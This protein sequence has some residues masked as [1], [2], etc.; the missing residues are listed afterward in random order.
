MLHI[1]HLHSIMTEALFKVQTYLQVAELHEELK[2]G[3]GLHERTQLWA[4]LV[5]SFP[6]ILV[7]I[8]EFQ[9]GDA[10]KL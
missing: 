1:E 3:T 5:C 6:G 4:S 8:A 7:H 10:G 2:V 9:N